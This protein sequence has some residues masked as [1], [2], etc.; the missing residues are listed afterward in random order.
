MHTATCPCDRPAPTATTMTTIR[1]TGHAA[2]HV[3]AHYGDGLRVWKHAD[4]TGDG[5]R[6]V[7]DAEARDIAAEDPSLLYVDVP[8]YEG[9]SIYEVDGCGSLQVVSAASAED[10]AQQVADWQYDAMAGEC[11]TLEW[12]GTG[13]DSAAVAE[14][15]VSVNGEEQP[16]RVVVRT[17]DV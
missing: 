5:A 14:Y 17:I 1:V 12:C 7:S 2:L 10:A 3:A 13:S 8:A 9:E 16:R 11:V 15:R 4:P 6:A